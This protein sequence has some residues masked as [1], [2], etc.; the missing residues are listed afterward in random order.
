MRQLERFAK[1]ITGAIIL[2]L[3]TMVFCDAQVRV[4]KLK[5]NQNLRRFHLREQLL[6]GTNIISAFTFY[7]VETAEVYT[8]DEINT[9]LTNLST[10]IENSI[11][12]INTQLTSLNNS[13]TELKTQNG[14]FIQDLQAAKQ[15]ELNNLPVEILNQMKGNPEL[16]S[17]IIKL[18]LENKEFKD[19]ITKIILEELKKAK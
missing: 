15:K 16:Q 6:Q 4:A 13:F 14:K 17:A 18:L 5:G 2:L 8:I 11:K 1:G 3:L 10:P 12:G 7:D 9:R 19:E